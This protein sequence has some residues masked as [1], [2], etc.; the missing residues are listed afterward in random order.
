M[1]Q[2]V[3]QKDMKIVQVQTSRVEFDRDMLNLAV[4]PQD[5]GTIETD[6]IQN[7]MCREKMSLRLQKQSKSGSF[8]CEPG[9][10]SRM[11]DLSTDGSSNRGHRFSLVPYDQYRNSL[12][13]VGRESKNMS[14]SSQRRSQLYETFN[15]INAEDVKDLNVHTEKLLDFF[16]LDNLS[17]KQD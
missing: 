17:S 3:L 1:K 12:I 15:Q 7:I 16:S 4:E 8:I 13:Q 10:L 14:V 11:N 9:A 6:A 5:F 2:L